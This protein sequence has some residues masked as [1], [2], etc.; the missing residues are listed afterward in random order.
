MKK[1]FILPFLLLLM[2]CSR[3][4]QTYPANDSDIRIMGRHLVDKDGSVKFAA[5]GVTFY[6]KFR[7][8]RM[9]AKL[10]DEF[11]DSTS[12]NWFDIILDGKFIR[13]FH[14]V[15]GET[16]YILA[17]SLQQGVHTLI[18]CKATE[19]QNGHNR[20]VNIRTQQLMQ[21]APLPS[22]KIEFIGDS[23]TCGFGDDTTLVPC[24]KGNWFDHT[25]A[26]FA[27]GPR[28]ARSLHAQW[29]LSAVSGIGMNRN[30]NSPGPVMPDVYAGVY[31]EYTK[32][33]VPWNFSKYTPDLV[34]ITL[35]TNDFSKGGGKI[36]RP[37]LD[38]NAFVKDYTGFV[39]MVR[40]KY[41]H[42]KFLLANSPMITNENKNVL[43]G[44]LQ[45][46]ID[47][48][49]SAGDSAIT[50]F[51]WMETYNKGCDGHPY[52]NQQ[53]KMADQLEPVVSRF[54]GW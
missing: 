5:S 37:P 24:N 34:V 16:H 11:R 21:S 29:M 43:D 52:M 41:P 10:D 46:V 23:I 47:N 28:L 36:P 15:M 25:N 19:G 35:G 22:R 39:A 9:D 45:R 18:L 27:Y 2:A 48:R 31:M 13:K 8:T 30:W 40:K 51:R 17:D 6:F 49:K 26:W 32:K 1:L 44:Y 50:R 4:M 7:G 12:Y 14:T 33:P 54:M 20:L 3:G 38:G 53:A 42:A